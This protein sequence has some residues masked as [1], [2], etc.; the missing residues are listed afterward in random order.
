[1]RRDPPSGGGTGCLRSPVVAS[2]EPQRLLNAKRFFLSY[3]LAGLDE[4]VQL[5]SPGVVYT[6]PGRHRLSGVFRGPDEVR[7][8]IADLVDFSR[9]TF[10]VLQWIDWLVGE[11]HVM[12]I[13]YAQAQHAGQIY[14]NH[15]LYLVES[16]ADA[17]VTDIKVYFEDLSAADGFF[18]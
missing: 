17:L 5:L 4:A 15:H 9:G 18:V 1:L 3:S 7:R 13:Q 16:D 12:A 2:S 10:E 8:H 14:R 11:S 6:V